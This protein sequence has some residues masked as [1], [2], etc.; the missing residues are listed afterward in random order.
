MHSSNL[1]I[2]FAVHDF[3]KRPINPTT[4]WKLDDCKYKGDGTTLMVFDTGID[5]T[6][7]SFSSKSKDMLLLLPEGGSYD[8]MDKK[9]HGTLCAGI[10]CGG[11]LK[12]T[13]KDGKPFVCCG[14]A[15]NAKL[16]IWK[17]H[18]AN[19]ETQR[20]EFRQELKS[21]TE[22]VQTFK[23]PPIDVLVIPSGMSIP[24]TEMHECIKTLDDKGIIIVC[25]GSND[26]AVSNSIAYP[27]R[28][29]Q[30][31]CI[32]SNTAG[33]NRSDF[34]PVGDKMD[35]LAVG[36]DIIGPRSKKCEKKSDSLSEDSS[37][38]FLIC[39]GTSFSAPAVGG[40]ICLIL[41]TL[42][43]KQ[44][45]LRIDEKLNRE[46]IVNLL[47]R[48]TNRRG[49]PK[50]REWGYGAIDRKRLEKFFKSPTEIIKEM[51]DNKDIMPPAPIS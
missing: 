29:S 18:N 51:R 36:E 4:F 12:G 8:D 14:V 6:H 38:M 3:Q 27:A 7:Q 47:K 33:L 48:L 31:I 13:L 45:V 41:Q 20:S 1:F 43:S 23:K 34:S 44:A 17:A 19:P 26:G 46:F 21:L 24:F 49:E 2:P 37:E 32:G 40:L 16:G 42:K 15:P 5:W 9:G 10:A 11:D 28:F 35:F 22:Y 39:K 50:D 30:T 25:S